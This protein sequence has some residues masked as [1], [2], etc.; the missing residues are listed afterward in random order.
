MRILKSSAQSFAIEHAGEKSTYP[1]TNI[2]KRWRAVRAMVRLIKS[3][4]RTVRESVRGQLA[5]Q[6]DIPGFQSKME[7]LMLTWEQIHEMQENGM[8]FGAHTL[9][10]LNLPNA[11]AADARK[12]IAECKTFMEEKLGIPVIHFS[13]PNSGPYEYFTPEVRNMVEQSEYISAVTSAAGFA[14]SNND[15]FAIKRVRTVPSL[16]ETVAGIELG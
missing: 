1:L 5:K 7:N 16:I 11:G 13:Y 12:E 14:E 4:D 6:L 8:I 2:V 15:F 9:T 3:N 10:H